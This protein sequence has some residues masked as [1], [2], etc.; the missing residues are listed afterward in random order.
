MVPQADGATKRLISKALLKAERHNKNI[1]I[2]EAVGYV[3][4]WLIGQN[5]CPATQVD[6]SAIIDGESITMENMHNFAHDFYNFKWAFRWNGDNYVFEKLE[7]V[8]N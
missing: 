1:Y 4:C 8:D 6:G 2:Y 3:G 7:K 5:I